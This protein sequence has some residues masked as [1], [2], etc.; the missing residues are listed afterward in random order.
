MRLVCCT[1][2]WLGKYKD[3]CFQRAGFEPWPSRLGLLVADGPE[4]IAGVMA[5][6]TTGP[7]VFFEHLVTNETAHPRLRW[8]AVDMIAG[9]VLNVC[10]L[11]GK[12]PQMLIRHKGIERIIKKHGLQS[13][14]AVAWSC[15]F[16]NLEKHDYEIPLSASESTRRFTDS[17]PTLR[18]PPGL[19]T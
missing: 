5:Y 2:P 7:F 13:T 10:R 6:D 14:K 1:E 16:Q 12:M 4:L 17:T 15:A 8:A 18:P 9:E 11:M 19:S 3:L